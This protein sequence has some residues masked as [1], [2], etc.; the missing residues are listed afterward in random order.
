MPIPTPPRFKLNENYTNGT[1]TINSSVLEFAT[2]AG[3]SYTILYRDN[4]EEPWKA[5]LP[6]VTAGANVMQWLDYGP[7]KTETPPGEQRYYQ[8]LLLP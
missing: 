8:V 5:S 6:S 4:I 7:P 3:R 2:T 1:V